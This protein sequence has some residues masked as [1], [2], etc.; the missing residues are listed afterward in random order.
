MRIKIA[1]LLLGCTALTAPRAWAQA[2]GQLPP[3]SPLPPMA[4]PGAPPGPPPGMT[5]GPS[6]LPTP[7][8]S[9]P[10][11]WMPQ[12]SSPSTAFALPPPALP[13]LPPASAPQAL[14]PP[15]APRILIAGRIGFGI[16]IYIAPGVISSAAQG[17]ASGALGGLGALPSYGGSL[18]IRWW[19]K[20][21]LV[22]LPSLSMS[23][24][25][26]SAPSVTD[27]FGNYTQGET[28]TSG[29]IAPALSLGY[30]AYR[31]K[32]T[33][34]LILGG[35]GFAYTAQGVLQ[36]IPTTDNTRTSRYV[37]AKTLGFNIPFGFALEQFFTPRISAVLGAQAPIFDYRSTKIGAAEAATSIGASFNA[38]QLGA[39]V[40]FYND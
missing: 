24:T 10:P 19:V 6:A 18:G 16:G 31:G 30:A 11:T 8:G 7:Q 27:T 37:T 39:S 28:F 22:V 12:G 13:T 3:G 29:V 15:E 38:T 14:P 34:V 33:R 25:R 20:E 1:A 35:V 17:G 21:R 26:T 32:S 9:P 2:P 23:I 40:Y 5:P 4:G 36:D